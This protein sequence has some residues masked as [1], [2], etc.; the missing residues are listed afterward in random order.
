M[1][2]ISAASG[3]SP[4]PLLHADQLLS[5]S[6]PQDAAWIAANVPLFE[7]PDADLQSIYY[8]RWHVCHRH[9][10]QTP[11]G[12]IVTEFLPD[13]KWAGKYNSICC[14]A[15]HHI[16]EGRWIRDPK[17]LDDYEAF[18][19]AP[20]G[21]NPRSYSFWAA[22]AIYA[23]YLVNADK[24]L[25]IALLPD[26]IKN[27][28][29]WESSHRDA[30]GL[31]WQIDDRDGMEYSVGGSGY[32]PTLNS[33]QYGD[34]MAI[35]HIADL[36]GKP[37]V[38]NE[39]RQKAGRIKQLVQEKLWNKQ[40][41]FFETVPRNADAPVGVRE[42]V[43]FVPWYFNLPD[44]GHESA[45]KQLLDPQGFAAPY[46]PTTVEQRSPRFNFKAKHDC[47]W[48]GPSWPYAT[49]QTLAAMA[50][51]LNNYSQDVIGKSDYLN[52]LRGYARS[53]Y[54]DGKPWIAEDLD[55]ATG[56]WIVDLP[57]SEDYNHSAYCDLIISGLIGLRPRADDVVEINPL[58]PQGTWDYFALEAIPYHG[59]PLTI[60]YDKNGTRYGKG[61]GLIVWCDGKQIARAEMIERINAKLAAAE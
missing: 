53:Q 24:S 42:E 56:K 13:V 7:C 61:K 16:Y 4:P 40:D 20:G 8:F 41:Q 35:S 9:I 51:L 43:G 25:V 34:A 52:L 6:D 39:F 15:G 49:T 10:R 58:V 27:Y 45:W 17:Y 5:Q 29:A 14:A 12:Y 30:S 36:A 48:N 46:G 11:L 44:A 59:H 3:E 23:R 22:D 33:Y 38:S 50:N 19:F 28:Q 32:R 2:L 26:L 31:Y 47:L 60:F 54:K 57:R 55:A 37:D 21:G 1:C 18:W